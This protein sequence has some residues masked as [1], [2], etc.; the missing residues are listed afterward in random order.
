MKIAHLADLHLGFP[1]GGGKLGGFAIRQR[2]QDVLKV[3]REAIDQVVAVK[4]DVI[5]IAG[6]I[7]H[8]PRPDNDV[9]LQAHTEFSALAK[10]TPG[11]LRV[12][13]A[14]NHDQGNTADAGCLLPLLKFCGFEVAAR[15]PRYYTKGDITVHAVPEGRKPGLKPAGNGVNVLLYHGEVNLMPARQS[16]DPMPMSAFAEWDYV[17]L[18]HYHQRADGPNGG[19]SGS[20]EHVS[21]DPWHEDPT[22]FG[23]VLWD[24]DTK[25]RTFFPSTPRPHVDLPVIEA[26]GRSVADIRKL[27]TQ[28]CR[29]VPDGAV[30]RQQVIG[31]LKED[32]QALAIDNRKRGERFLRYV[33]HRVKFVEIDG[34]AVTEY[35]EDEP[36]IGANG[37]IDPYEQ[38]YEDEGEFDAE[39]RRR[40]STL[41]KEPA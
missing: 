23:W 16:K 18:G 13:V 32:A 2:T 17:A 10:Q 4:P 40:S 31:L 6:D 41:T 39:A 9:V 14:G 28:N 34:R 27:L 15:E 3:F 22:R 26:H 5:V 21:S 7:F 38:F 35:D 1:P 36:S 20:L 37:T 29:S 11:A 19:Y 24:T 25:E 30:V 12:M 33:L 8:M